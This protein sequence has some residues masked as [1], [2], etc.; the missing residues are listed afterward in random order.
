MLTGPASGAVVAG[1]NVSTEWVVREDLYAA[2]G[3]V[4]IR[5]EV[6]GDL[7][8]AGGRVLVEQPIKGDVAAAGGEVTIRA[9]VAD[10]VRA[11]GGSVTIDGPV[12]GDVMAAGGRIVLPA[13]ANIQGRAGLAGS[14]I[15]L[16][17]HVGRSVRA[18]GKRIRISGQIDGDV[19]LA[20]G[21]VEVLATARIAGTLTYRSGRP[22][23]IE[24]GAQ[25]TGGV[26]HR[27]FT[28]GEQAS[29]FVRLLL[30]G[31]ALSLLLAF[32]LIGIVLL[33]LFPE[34]TRVAARRIATDPGPSFALGLLML[35]GG[36]V[37]ILLLMVT[38]V[39]IPLG[40]GL[41]ALYVIWLLAGFLIGVLFLGDLGVRALGRAPSRGWRLL[42][43][44]IALAVM[45]VL[46]AIPFV[47]GLALLAALVF[48]VGAW[49]LHVA[50]GYRRT[51]SP[52]A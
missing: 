33:A 13:G 26:V 16:G 9:A 43:L 37:A 1:G 41:A 10:D 5:G 28:A 47:G 22:A 3:E 8:A 23:R 14:A 31:L 2:G 4:A 21:S 51:D 30:W 50:R 39:G 48:G 52:P 44:L 20:A 11:V 45:G 7:V 12:A 17:G 36:P 15:E 25:V 34:G 27:P 38:V 46:Q 49:S 18:A 19:D 6:R 32:V 42:G 29:R 40:L 24:P 35:L